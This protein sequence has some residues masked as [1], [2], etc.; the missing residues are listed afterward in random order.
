MTIVNGAP[1]SLGVPAHRSARK[2]DVMWISR[3]PSSS[4]GRFAAVDWSTACPIGSSAR[5]W[6][7]EGVNQDCFRSLHHKGHR[8]KRPWQKLHKQHFR[9]DCCEKKCGGTIASRG[10]PQVHSRGIGLE[11]LLGPLSVVPWQRGDAHETQHRPFVDRPQ[12]HLYFGPRRQRLVGG[13][14]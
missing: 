13:L 14:S 11:A 5:F 9:G 7:F 6:S 3:G 2:T 12:W 1:P 4:R 8:N 10:S